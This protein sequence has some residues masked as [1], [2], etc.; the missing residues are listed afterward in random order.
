MAVL[1]P[2]P[3]PVATAPSPAELE[4]ALEAHRRDLTGYCYRMLG[5]G[6]EA[7]DA[8]QETLV[9]AWRGIDRFEGRSSLRSWL[10]P[11]SYTHLTLPTKA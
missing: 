8:A 2:D 4:A 11:V 3:R 5:S 9:R 6:A 10:Y 1:P 7:E